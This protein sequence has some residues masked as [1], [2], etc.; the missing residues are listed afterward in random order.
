VGFFATS[1][2]LN[3]RGVFG[4]AQ[5][6][7]PSSIAG[8]SFWL[9]AT[10]GLFDATSGGNPV[11]TDGSSVARW[12]DQS[13]NSR[14]ITQTTVGARPILKTAIQNGKNIIRFDGTDDIL[15]RSGAFVHA[16]GAAT[17]F[18]VVS[19]N[20][21][22]NNRRLMNEGRTANTTS[23]YMPII[24][25]NAT[26]FQV[27]YRLDNNTIPLNNVSF[28]TAFN[29]TG[30]KLVC[31]LDSGTNFAGF[32]NKVTTNNQNYTRGTVT[33]DT[34]AIGGWAA[35]VERDF[36]PGDVAEVVIYNTALGTTD[37]QSVE[38]YLYSKWGIV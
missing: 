35:N 23:L 19:A 22:V 17:I 37:R 31:A 26:L 15:R 21:A 14:H 2:I 30:F 25:T 8:L 18:V 36:F 20:T 12:E 32:I 27:L 34:F 29:G 5:A 9:D 13:G 4:G 10:T 28:G 24:S 3:R 16:Q 6:F 38:N 7:S 33:L 1:G 11:T